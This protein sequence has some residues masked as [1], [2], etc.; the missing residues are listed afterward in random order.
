MR[1]IFLALITLISGIQSFSQI[2]ALTAT[3][4]E[5]VLYENGTWQYVNDSLNIST[6]EVNGIP[7]YKDKHSTFLIKSSKTDVG[8]WINP[9][10]WRFSK[11]PASSAAEYTFEIKNNDIQAMLI[12]EKIEIPIEN[13]IQIAYENALD[14]APDA[15]IIKQEYR[16]VNGLDVIM[17]Q[18]TGTISGIKF[19]YYSYYYS[20]SSGSYQ[21]VSYTSQNLFEAS[22][23][24]MEE[25]LNGFVEQ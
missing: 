5:V 8:L 16:I 15:K 17:M 7:Y 18:I 9:K 4:D 24:D 13:L 12:T 1:K 20:N 2:N 22:K 19:I 3:G 23:K 25:F 11:A 6:I 10:K 14:A 21:L